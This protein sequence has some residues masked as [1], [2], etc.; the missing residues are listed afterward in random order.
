MREG[1][2]EIAVAVNEKKRAL[3]WN[4]TKRKE[5]TGAIGDY[6]LKVAAYCAVNGKQEKLVI[7]CPYALGFDYTFSQ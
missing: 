5:L 6:F 1:D 2:I 7:L 3:K 4:F